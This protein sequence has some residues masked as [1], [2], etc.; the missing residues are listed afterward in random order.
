MTAKPT[1]HPEI[2][3]ASGGPET[4]PTSSQRTDGWAANTRPARQLFHWLFKKCWEWTQYVASG[5]FAFGDVAPDHF[6]AVKRGTTKLLPSTTSGTLTGITGS[7]TGVISGDKASAA[8]AAYA[9]PANSDVYFDL[10]R[11]DGWSI[12]T[13]ASGAG[14]PAIAS[15]TIRSHRVRTNASEIVE[16][17]DIGDD[18]Y[19]DKTV[20][21]SGLEVR[22]TMVI[23]EDKVSITTFSAEPRIEYRVASFLQASVTLLSRLGVGA[24]T[25]IRVYHRNVTDSSQIVL[26]F[27]AEFDQGSNQW[28]RGNALDESYLVALSTNGLAIYNHP[29]GG[30]ATWSDTFNSASHWGSMFQTGP[31]SL[32]ANNVRM[33]SSGQLTANALAATGDISAGAQLIGL[34][35]AILD[36]PNPNTDANTL[37]KANVPKAWGTFTTD[38][39]SGFSSSQLFGV[40]SI[41]FSGLTVEVNFLNSMSSA[42][43]VVL[44]SGNSQFLVHSSTGKTATQ[45]FINAASGAGSPVDLS[46]QSGIT[47]DFVVFGHQT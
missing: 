13:V 37:Y 6:I 11:A 1:D 8:S 28:S 33:N 25:N 34:S 19:G 30:T 46:A 16:I 26:T 47:I 39:A 31:G 41:A 4:A 38:G 29:N 2:N 43:Y 42:Q 15:D 32:D 3:S 23:G 35:A 27:N 21:D 45:F 18:A 17:E 22:E 20:I 44:M 40:S 14:A 5:V 36:D 7:R 12:T 24:A 10:Q 9:F